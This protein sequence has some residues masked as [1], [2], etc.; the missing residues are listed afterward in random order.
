VTAQ[1]VLVVH[2][3]SSIG[4]RISETARSLGHEAVL[5]HDGERAID[6]FVQTPSDALVVN[7]L[8]PARDGV[9]TVETIRWA[10]GG[11]RVPVILTAQG[12][13]ERL[14]KV[15]RYLNAVATL[16]PTPS[17]AE[18]GHALQQAL[19]P[20]TESSAETRQLHV[21]Q[22]AYRPRESPHEQ[23]TK[24]A[25]VAS[26]APDEAS[27][28]EGPAQTSDAE[29]PA[30]ASEA[31]K[32]AEASEA[33]DP[34]A[35]IEGDTTRDPEELR[36]GREVE[37]RAS[38]LDRT[39]RLEGNL[40]E[41]PFPQLLARLA[42][43][44]STGALVI[45]SDGD[46][47]RTTTGESP[48]KVVFFRNGVPQHLRSNL[49]E[50]CL[51]QVLRR[52]GQID[53]EA[54]EDSLRQVR[55]G[56]GR[57]GAVL[58]AMGALE[59]H[60]LRDAL[61]EQ[62]RLKLFDLFGWTSGSFRFS[63]RMSPPAETV[64]LEMSLTEIV[65]HGV[66]AK[67]QPQRL[68]T[69]LQPHLGKYVVPDV[70]RLRP[71]VGMDVPNE[72]RQVVRSL[73]GTQ[74]LSQLLRQA[75]PRP[76]AAAQLL[77]ALECVGAVH[78]KEQPQPTARAVDE[79]SS[80]DVASGPAHTQRTLARRR[81]PPDDPPHD[82][83]NPTA[84]L[85]RGEIRRTVQQRMGQTPSEGTARPATDEG[86]SKAPRP[87]ETGHSSSS[88]PPASQ[89]WNSPAERQ[90]MPDGPGRSPRPGRRHATDSASPESSTP[91][92]RPDEAEDAPA[93]GGV[94]H[95]GRGAGALSLDDRVD[96][97]VQ[98]E[99]LFRRGERALRRGRMQ[100]ALSAF[101]HSVELCPEEGEFL[102]WLGYTRHAA[103]PG[104]ATASR[105]ACEELAR[106]CALAPKLDVA[107]L[108]RARVLRSLG[109]LAAARDAYERALAANPD[110]TEALESLREIAS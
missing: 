26:R 93:T 83:S 86:G 98:A 84:S 38:T 66:V 105:Q 45:H 68:L 41:V 100:Q 94:H 70:R 47:R 13:P 10:P 54:L 27:E 85:H 96:R 14:D 92:A 18:I 110:C 52:S 91:P 34:G 59:P 60:E 107:H 39:A 40:S 56:A 87:A 103:A 74:P 72:V 9:A 108:L 67:L 16:S 15:S 48:K 4:Q 12:D 55:E 35:E 28:A 8:L 51:G 19:P 109:E 64:T 30:Q 20:P 88:E 65:Y 24:A 22:P 43:L 75:D 90:T 25:A 73:D 104:D 106:G 23:A 71:F 78:Y 62:Q 5:V 53:D 2:P 17:A 1:T 63:E 82:A 42:D 3:D 50:E 44:R 95:A 31:A 76:G 81:P 58:I 77:Y 7:L 32:A 49:V 89:D 61:E 99:R 11:E 36:E 79:D 21:T 101:E 57:Q 46:K 97:M 29:G 33:A 37:L 69:R 6:Q 80:E 102:A